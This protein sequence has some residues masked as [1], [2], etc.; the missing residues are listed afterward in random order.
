MNERLIAMIRDFNPWWDGAEV[1]VPDYKRHIFAEMHRFVKPKQIIAVVGLRRVGKTVLLKQIIR[2]QL[3]LSGESE[4]FFYFL[5][6]EL[7]VQSPETLSDLL[8]YYLKTIAGSGRKFIFFD[9]IQKVPFW[10][11][12]LKRF[13]DTRDD[14][15]FFVSGSASLQI[16][17]SKESLAGRIFD[18]HMPILTFREFLELNGIIIEKIGLD[19]SEMKK[20]YESRL[21]RKAEFEELF[22]KYVLKGAFPEIAKEED[23]E[24]IKSYIKSSVIEKI[25]FEDIPAVFEVKRKDILVQ[26]LEYCCRE[27]SNLLDISNLAKTLSIN[28]QTCRSYLFYLEKSFLIDLLFN[29]SKSAAKQLRKSKKVHIAHPAITVT[30]MRYGQEIL[31][32]GE[33]MGLFIETIAFQHAKLLSERL[34]F[35]RSPQKEEVDLVLTQGGLLPI[36]VK[37]KN[38]VEAKDLSP[39]LKFM[40]KQNLHKG[41]IV[42]KNQLEKKKISG[43]EILLIPAWLFLLAA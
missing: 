33:V 9:E 37:F 14:L 38:K 22:R 18:F 26:I 3:G 6:D 13:Y 10:Q 21:H 15:K 29:Y 25:I 41:I 17:K 43:K 28:Y 8:D 24:I 16:K 32:V 35:W 40:K 42:S 7:S 12:V 31:N 23:A 2:E 4:N 36:E 5:F 1:S 20:A 39:L 27:T 19:F 34:S 30:L 11:D